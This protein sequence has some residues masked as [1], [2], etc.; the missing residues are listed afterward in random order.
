MSLDPKRLRR[1]VKQRERLEH[2]QEGVLAAATRLHTERLGALDAVCAA[3]L[4]LFDEGL[5]R[6]GAVDPATLASASAYVVRLERDIEARRAALAHSAAGVEAE[7]LRLLERR[8]DRKAMEVLLDHQ[9]AEQR[10]RQQ[11]AAGL[12]LDEIASNRWLAS[13]H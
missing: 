11:R 12:V 10:L 5:V 1:L 13:Q 9:L 3:R 8:R 4:A 2:V 7:R 6:G